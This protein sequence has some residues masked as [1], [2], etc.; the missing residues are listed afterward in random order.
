MGEEGPVDPSEI[1][2]RRI[3]G[4]SDYYNPSLADPV[5]AFAF[6]P[7]PQDID[8]ISLYRELFVS[9]EQVAS[10]ARKPAS[11][12]VVARLL[13]SD[14][15]ALGLTIAPTPGDGSL[16]GHVSIPEISWPAYNDR[17]KKPRLAEMNKRLAILAGK[18][19]V[20]GF[21]TT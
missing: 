8:G 16:P 1:I 2:L 14:I 13:A 11:S 19:I 5:L 9:P 7:T 10:K 15:L 21:G 12:Y 4:S 18:D 17:S 6:R 20:S 3:P